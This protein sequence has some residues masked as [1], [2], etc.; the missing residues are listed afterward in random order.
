MLNFY[1]QILQASKV[2]ISISLIA[3]GL[4]L[5]LGAVLAFFE[6]APKPINYL[7]S[8]L[9]FL[10]RSLPEIVVLLVCY[11]GL[12]YL[13]R[14]VVGHY[15][16]VNPFY[17]GAVILSL[18]MA[19]YIAKIFIGAYKAISKIEIE[20]CDALGLSVTT[21]YF[22]IIVPN[23]MRHSIPALLNLW[24]VL[25]KDSSIVSLIGLHDIMNMSHTAAS[26]TFQPFNYY[27]F[28][29]LIYLALTSVSTYT[30]KQLVNYYRV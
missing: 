13:L 6:S 29:A 26:Q 1:G 3:F 28:A 30:G 5:L 16:D 11:Y 8:L 7:F 23:I 25:L 20:A 15:V 24:L 21:K 17:S 4:G 19:A 12:S 14:H 2:T 27:F 22:S 10:I 9:N 18:I